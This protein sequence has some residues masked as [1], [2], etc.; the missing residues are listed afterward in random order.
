M[1]FVELSHVFLDEIIG[2]QDDC[3]AFELRSLPGVSKVTIGVGT[4]LPL[5]SEV[6]TKLFKHILW[7]DVHWVDGLVT[8]VKHT[9][10]FLLFG[11]S[12]NLYSTTRLLLPLMAGRVGSLAQPLRRVARHSYCLDSSNP[13]RWR[14]K[15]L[16]HHGGGVCLLFVLLW[17][18]S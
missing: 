2:N 5:A 9:Q 4:L 16:H 12:I 1:V 8:E 14:A 6:G 7:E 11:G 13:R 15:R 18:D 3:L 17:M 10:I